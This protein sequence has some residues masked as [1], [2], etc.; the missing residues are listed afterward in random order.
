MI[1]IDRLLEED[2]KMLPGKY[3]SA[4]IFY[5][6]VRYYSNDIKDKFIFNDYYKDGQSY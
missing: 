2:D 6:L 1:L 3:N 5:H 4:S